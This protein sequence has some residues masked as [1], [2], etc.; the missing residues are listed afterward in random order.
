MKIDNFPL[1]PQL[2]TH[3]EFAIF[4]VAAIAASVSPDG[5]C[6]L[7]DGDFAR[8][9]KDSH[10]ERTFHAYRLKINR[11]LQNLVSKKVLNLVEPSQKQTGKLPTVKGLRP[12]ISMQTA[13]KRMTKAGYEEVSKEQV[14]KNVQD[15]STFSKVNEQGKLDQDEP[16]PLCSNEQ[17]YRNLI[18]CD[19]KI[20][21]IGDESDSKGI[22]ANEHR[23]EV[24]LLTAQNILLFRE[25]DSQGQLET[26]L[27]SVQDRDWSKCTNESLIIT[28]VPRVTVADIAKQMGV[29]TCI[30]CKHTRSVPP[31]RFCKRC[32]AG[33]GEC[34]EEFDERNF[35]T[36][37][38]KPKPSPIINTAALLMAE[39][40]AEA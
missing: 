8:I 23:A 13:M 19:S 22:A 4:G 34:C 26:L 32:D 36:N 20:P 9:L 11:N 6:R 40:G 38:R 14:L 16:D 29:G 35:K 12:L 15:I 37:N 25:I 30:C 18:Y 1:N 31:S 33:M 17:A 7:T 10:T 21:L 3:E 2:L 5:I 24:T 27:D 28:Q 39:L